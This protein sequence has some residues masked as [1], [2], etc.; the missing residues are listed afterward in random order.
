MTKVK[1]D[2]FKKL[3]KDKKVLELTNPKIVYIPLISQND[4][5]I[6]VLVKKGDTVLKGSI[7][8]KRKGDIKSPIFSSVSG[9]VI[10]FEEKYYANGNLEKCIVI[11][12]DNKNKLVCEEE[13]D[14]RKYTKKQ[15]LDKIK[16]LGIVGLS[17]SGFPTYLKYN[18]DSINTL[19]INAVECEPYITADYKLIEKYP[20]EILDIIDAVMEINGIKEGIIAIKKTNKK[21]VKILNN[22]IGSYLN[23]KIKLVPN[24][25]PMGWERTL[26][27][28]V[29]NVEYEKLPIEK[30]IVVNNVTTMY[31]IY[32]A[33]KFNL[34]I[35]ERIVT[36]TGNIIKEPK[37]V[38]VSIGTETKEILKKVGLEKESDIVLVAGG[39]MMGKCINND[40]LVISPNVNCVLVNKFVECKDITCLRCGKCINVCPVRIKP[41]MIK[42]NV[43]NKEELQKLHPEKCIQCGLCSY[44]CPSKIDVRQYVKTAK[45]HE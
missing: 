8:G 13:H 35:T 12:N 9:K 2:G 25:Y 30:N 5:D 31:A 6:T 23:I 33:L 15:F 21:L 1:L 29:K 38:I 26:V 20:E 42:D 37:N 40:S 17:G 41:V 7:L 44:I 28:Q 4:T 22:Y 27:K 14:I 43:R 10:G 3:T 18:N 24:I 36:I 16:E 39:P 19:I 32:N 11:E 45:E 34:P